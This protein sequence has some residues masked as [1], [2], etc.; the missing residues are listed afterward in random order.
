MTSPVYLW[1]EYREVRLHVC[2][3]VPLEGGPG[4]PRAA[5]GGRGALRRARRRCSVEGRRA[6]QCA[7]GVATCTSRSKEGP[8]RPGMRIARAGRAL[9]AA[10]VACAGNTSQ[11][12]HLQS[13]PEAPPTLVLRL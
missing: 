9:R 11:M 4:G 13:T 10:A 5:G 7:Q 3:Y 1:S 12:N 8:E 6:G 2:A